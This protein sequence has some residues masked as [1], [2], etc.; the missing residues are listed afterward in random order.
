[1]TISSWPPPP[2]GE[3]EL[4]RTIRSARRE[5]FAHGG[6]ECE[7]GGAIYPDGLVDRRTCGC[8]PHP[9]LSEQEIA[10]IKAEWRRRA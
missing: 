7:C 1:M 8:G 10:R 2:S 3:G 6:R 5:F 4:E 9:P